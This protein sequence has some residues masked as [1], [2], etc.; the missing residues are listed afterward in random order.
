MIIKRELTMDLN[1]EN[2]KYNNAFII[3]L[4]IAC[5]SLYFFMRLYSKN[6]GYNIVFLS[7]FF[8]TTMGLF[9]VFL[10]KKKVPILI[11]FL[12][13]MTFILR[14][15]YAYDIY[16]SIVSPFPDSFDY[17]IMLDKA[18][19]ISKYDFS[20]ISHLAGSLHFGYLY[21]MIITYK[22]FN[23]Y[24]ALYLINIMLFNLSCILLYK[25]IYLDFGK[26]I[27]M[28][29]TLLG[30]LSMN[31]L[32]FTSNILKDSLVLFLALTSL[33]LYKR[34][35]ADSIG[36]KRI[37]LLL[38]III[39]LMVL[40][41]TRI[42]TAVAFFLA[43]LIDYYV[44]HSKKNLKGKL[45]Y[46]F[47]LLLLIFA[48]MNS[49]ILSLYYV[50]IL[51]Y[52]KSF[53]YFNYLLKLPIGIVKIILSPLPWNLLTNK[54]HYIILTTDSIFL[55]LFN[56]YIIF[57]LKKVIQYKELRNKMYI[58]IIPILVHSA[59][60]GLAYE[61]N[62]TRQRIAVFFF[63]ITMYVIGMMYKKEQCEC[64]H[65]RGSVSSE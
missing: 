57:F 29:S 36:I 27:A 63:I 21:L 11:L 43:M 33:Y 42:Y 34:F 65:V 28:I 12:I 23:N 47:I 22:I 30:I 40:L 31:M 55:L 16:S 44:N 26:K 46:I 17:I 10:H 64:N 14:I 56:F 59:T 45:K 49:S 62:S 60:F 13:N 15:I 2:K 9:S 32:L 38:L 48:I 25:I 50:N 4:I 19:L 52:A 54:S 61:G 58:Y 20:T 41:F 5:I 39:V 51:H 35:I 24:F 37:V 6:E 53:S 3:I 7:L 8:L 18:I 1:V